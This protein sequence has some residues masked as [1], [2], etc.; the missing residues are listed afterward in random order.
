[1]Y[2]TRLR[3]YRKVKKL[4][5]QQLADLIGIRQG[6]L[7][8]L[9][10]GKSSPSAN[11]LASLHLHTDINVAWLLT[12]QGPMI[13]PESVAEPIN[14]VVTPLR[15][16]RGSNRDISRMVKSLKAVM[17]SKNETLKAAL[18]ADLIAFESALRDNEKIEGL[19]RDMDTLK[20]I[21]R[22]SETIAESKE[23]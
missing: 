7:S 20:K 18:R 1:M 10:T 11:T 21:I 4:T 6:P 2:G 23:M 16:D 9:E 14:Y 8:E 22:P 3:E 13:R 12:G 19:E 15:S 5:M 17:A